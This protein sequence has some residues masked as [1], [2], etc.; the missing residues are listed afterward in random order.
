MVLGWSIFFHFEI[1]L[2]KIRQA[3]WV[4]NTLTSIISDEMGL[5]SI[6]KIFGGIKYFEP[7]KE[8]I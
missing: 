6:W 2:Q 8:K 3:E 7:G 5:Q 4:C 1:L